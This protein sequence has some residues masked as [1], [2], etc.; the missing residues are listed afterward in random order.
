[1]TSHMISHDLLQVNRDYVVEC[2]FHKNPVLKNPIEYRFEPHDK[3][4]LSMLSKDHGA[5]IFLEK[6]ARKWTTR[7][8]KH[9]DTIAATQRQIKGLKSVTSAYTKVSRVCLCSGN[10]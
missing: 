8:V 4:S 7:L 10:L 3:D 9:Q 1:M 2:F 6:D 5:E